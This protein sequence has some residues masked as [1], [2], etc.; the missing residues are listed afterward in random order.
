MLH[1]LLIVMTCVVMASL[2]EGLTMILKYRMIE[3][4]YNNLTLVR[5]FLEHNLHR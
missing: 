4:S 3:N 2:E 5:D 1:C